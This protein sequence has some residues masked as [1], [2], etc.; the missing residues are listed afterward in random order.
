MAHKSFSRRKLKILTGTIC[1]VS[2]QFPETPFHSRKCETFG[3]FLWLDRK[4]GGEKVLP[5]CLTR[6]RSRVGYGAEN[7]RDGCEDKLREAL[8][9][10]PYQALHPSR[11]QHFHTVSIN[12]NLILTDCLCSFVSMVSAARVT[13]QRESFS[14][15]NLR[16]NNTWRF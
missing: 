9:S 12:F 13:F 11:S 16:L 3:I 14:R 8:G 15:N 1:C 10:F 7:G 2:C 4:R 6:K 5:I